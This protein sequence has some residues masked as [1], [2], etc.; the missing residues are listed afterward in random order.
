MSTQIII[1]F[2]LV[3]KKLA[4]ANKIELVDFFS[5]KIIIVIIKL[6]QSVVVIV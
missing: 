4:H 3:K 5:K 2:I 1:I 6:N